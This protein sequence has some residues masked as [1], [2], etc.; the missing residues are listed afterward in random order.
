M[1]CAY[2]YMVRPAMQEGN[3][4]FWQKETLQPY[5]RHRMR[6]VADPRA[7]MEFAHLPV[8]ITLTVSATPADG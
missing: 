8:L 7:L 2:P 5:I 4:C 6:V 1:R 3:R